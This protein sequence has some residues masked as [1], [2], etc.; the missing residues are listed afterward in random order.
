MSDRYEF[1]AAADCP[2][3]LVGPGT[4]LGPE[5][6]DAGHHALVLGN[7][8]SAA[9]VVEGSAPELR[10][11]VEE[12]RQALL[13]L[14]AEPRY[15]H[16]LMSAAQQALAGIGLSAEAGGGPSPGSIVLEATL[17]DGTVLTVYPGSDTTWPGNEDDDFEFTGWY[18]V[19]A[20][21]NAPDDP[22]IDVITGP[23][24]SSGD[25]DSPTALV[26]CVAA[27]L[28]RYVAQ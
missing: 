17:H 15:T 6:V 1:V 3:T 11:F 26:R 12:A 24:R 4:E 21:P 2:I 16:P 28:A 18:V 22:T 20:S 8:S 9:L 10:A 23:E 19:H 25:F 13:D 7:P 27:Y 5:D 14:P